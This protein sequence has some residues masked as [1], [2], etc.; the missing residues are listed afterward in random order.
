MIH[1]YINCPNVFSILIN[2]EDQEQ[3]RQSCTTYSAITTYMYTRNLLSPEITP[4]IFS[5]MN[6]VENWC[7][8]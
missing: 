2:K 1:V 3:E 8:R 4:Q 5:D 6:R 7:L